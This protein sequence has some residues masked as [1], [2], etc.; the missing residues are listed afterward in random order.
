MD[1]PHELLYE[2][3]LPANFWLTG[4][5]RKCPQ[6]NIIDHYVVKGRN[7]VEVTCKCGHTFTVQKYKRGERPKARKGGVWETTQT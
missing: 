3:P 1:E 5:A 6:C 4:L 2:D 7:P